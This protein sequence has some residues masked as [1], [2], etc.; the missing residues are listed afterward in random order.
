MAQP[1]VSSALDELGLSRPDPLA[2]IQTIADVYGP[3]QFDADLKRPLLDLAELP[4]PL[5]RP[6]GLP[7]GFPCLG[8]GQHLN[9]RIGGGLAPGDAA[10]IGAGAAGFGKTAFLGNL[11][12]GLA[13]RSVEIVRGE[14]KY[15]NVLTPVV[16]YSEMSISALMWRSLASLLKVPVNCFRAGSTILQAA[17]DQ[18][19]REAILRA[20][21][22]A[23]QWL[24]PDE[25]FG[26]S[27]RW[28]AHRKS[29]DEL[30]G[31]VNTWRD[32]L[33]QKYPHMSVVPVV[34]LDPI[35]R[36]LDPKEH[37]VTALNTLSTR[38]TEQASGNE[39][40]VLMTSDTNKASAGG[41]EKSVDPQ[42]MGANAFRGSYGLIHSLDI[43]L[44]LRRPKDS[45]RFAPMEVEVVLPK[46]RWG[47]TFGGTA[48]QPF[49]RFDWYGENL[50]FVPVDEAE[51][52]HRV[53]AEFKKKPSKSKRTAATQKR[54][55]AVPAVSPVAAAEAIMAPP[56][57]GGGDAPPAE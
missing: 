1:E 56:T 17:K 7:V 41:K 34:V 11:I 28:I 6:D 19:E 57:E 12:D 25:L 51:A 44:F 33:T 37:E 10:G 2:R 13:M 18:S 50:R 40:I 22:H 4:A 53:A 24:Q 16:L 27:R 29:V 15:G 49:P 54:P 21:S 26:A 30:E 20:R 3:A 52:S 31:F 45:Q 38:L 47:S 46:N 43:A 39:F 35:Q 8:L 23:K 14:T 42:E 5:N 32:A 48:R 55:N 9:S 36:F